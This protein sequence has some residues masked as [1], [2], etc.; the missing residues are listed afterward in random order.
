MSLKTRSLG[1]VTA[2]VLLAGPLATIATAGPASAAVDCKYNCTTY[3]ATKQ[4]ATAQ[5]NPGTVVSTPRPRATRSVS[6][7]SGVTSTPRAT[8][9]VSAPTGVGGSVPSARPSRHVMAPTNTGSLV[10]GGVART[11]PA[12]RGAVAAPTRKVRVS[13]STTTYGGAKYTYHPASFWQTH[14]PPRPGSQAYWPYLND[15]YVYSNYFNP[16]SPWHVYYMHYHTFY[17]TGYVVQ[18]GYFVPVSHNSSI[19]ADV[20]FAIL[21]IIVLIVLVLVAVYL[22]RRRNS[23]GG[24]NRPRPRRQ[25]PDVSVGGGWNR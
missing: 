12:A 1:L 3:K 19:G 9:S 17:V 15:P 18:D 14:K 6:V 8:R 11:A 23:G 22:L 2:A 16:L 10:V 20:G 4:T 5:L 13:G 24:G 7:P 25:D 21:G